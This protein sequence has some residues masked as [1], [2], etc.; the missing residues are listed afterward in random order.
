MASSSSESHGWLTPPVYLLGALVLI[1]VGRL[2][3]PG[4][5]YAT[6]LTL[7]IGATLLVGGAA[8]GIAGR[9][10]FEK[11]ETALSP[12]EAPS[13]LVVSGV[14]GITRNPMYLGMTLIVMAVALLAG[15]PAGVMFG[16]L[17]VGIMNWRFVPAEER[18]LEEA[19][20]E[21]YLRYK[22]TVRRWI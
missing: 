21:P 11:R 10:A 20:G 2:A 4:S 7:A 18:V 14:F 19:F 17:F 1:A 15:L 16:V 13:E 8:L 6:S 12:N 3:I 22:S 5:A 9:R